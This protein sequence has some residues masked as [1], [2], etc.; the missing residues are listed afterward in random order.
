MKVERFAYILALILFALYGLLLAY[1]I[2]RNEPISSPVFAIVIRTFT[3]LIAG[4]LAAALPGTVIVQAELPL[5]LG[6]RLGIQAVCGV[7]FAVLAYIYTPEVYPDTFPVKFDQ[8]EVLPESEPSAELV[9]KPGDGIAPTD[10]RR[11]D[12]MQIWKLPLASYFVTNNG[13]KVV[14]YRSSFS[15]AFQPFKARVQL[16][17]YSPQDPD[18]WNRVFAMEPGLAFLVRP[19]DLIEKQLRFEVFIDGNGKNPTNDNLLEFEE[20]NSSCQLL[21]IV[22]FSARDGQEKEFDSNDVTKLVRVINLDFEGT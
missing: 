17:A 7:A 16:T 1:V 11:V 14:V 22:P 3:A 15:R 21:L 19:P 8:A 5:P 13:N 20:V 4:L 10:Q 12:Q 2:I 6:G 18:R 9:P